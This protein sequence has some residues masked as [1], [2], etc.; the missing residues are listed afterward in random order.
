MP[1]QTKFQAVFVQLRA[2]LEKYA[3]HLDVEQDGPSGYSLN[4]RYIMKNKQPLFFGA[5]QIKKNYVSYYLMPVYSCP[6]LD[7]TISADLRKHMQGKSCFNFKDVNP[8]LFEELD[9]L[10]RRGFERYREEQYV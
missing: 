4:T 6:G 2:V 10:T 1:D 5:V 9:Q 7:Q 3:P 8:A